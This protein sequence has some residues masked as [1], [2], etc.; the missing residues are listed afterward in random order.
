MWHILVNV[1]T[2]YTVML[3]LNFQSLYSLFLDGPAVYLITINF[4]IVEH[5]QLY[6]MSR[7]NSIQPA[8]RRYIVIFIGFRLGE[9]YGRNR[10]TAG[11]G[12][13]I[14]QG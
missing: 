6:L 9:F 7:L 11:I 5:P 12:L 13:V 14:Q 1:D 8:V 3:C 10:C 4:A 2:M